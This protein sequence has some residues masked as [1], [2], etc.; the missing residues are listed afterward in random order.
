LRIANAELAAFQPLLPTLLAPEGELEAELALAP[1]GKVSGELRIRNARTR[2]LGA[3]GP[4]RNIQVDLRVKDR[5]LELANASAQLGGATVVLTGHVDLQGNY[6]LWGELPPFEVSLRGEEVPLTRQPE[7]IIRSDL[8]LTVLHTNGAPPL[9]TGEAHLRDS[10]FLSD[11][12]D[13]LPGGVA[14]PSRRPPYFSID[15]PFLANWRLAVQVDGARFL[16]VRSSLF[17]GEV[18]ANLRLQGTLKEPI[19]LGDLRVDS[20]TVRFPFATLEVQ[21]GLIVLTIQDPYRPQITLSATSKQYGYDLRM[22][23]TGTVDS[24]VLQFNSS[25]PLSSDQILLMVTAGQLPQGTYNLTPQQKAQ[26]VAMFLGRDV[27]A[28]L[29]FGDQ[30]Q[31]RL[32]IRSGEEVTEQ[33]R[34]T[35][36]VEYKLSDRWSL[37]GEYD[38]F[39][40]FN[41]GFKWRI[42][43][44]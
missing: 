43:S 11:L 41:A 32:T 23:V 26:T 9:V 10:Y 8:R 17:L 2:P 16:K 44:K 30:T 38:R 39:G 29:G 40:D 6:W 21:Q 36:H 13:L 1:G 27:L 19:A 3:T 28:K 37:E 31:P 5:L 7:S 20:G 34:P 22:D 35:Y 12:S 33:G 15:E 14:S 42:Y 18:S 4:L 24:P 25:P